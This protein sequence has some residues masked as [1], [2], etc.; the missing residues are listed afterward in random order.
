ML[1]SI[2]SKINGNNVSVDYSNNKTGLVQSKTVN[3]GTP[4]TYSYD[5][6][7]QVTS[8]T[9]P[10]ET[11]QYDNVGNLTCNQS[12]QNLTYNSTGELNYAYSTCG[13]TTTQQDTYTYDSYGDRVEEQFPFNGQNVPEYYAY[14]NSLGEMTPYTAFFT[15]TNYTYSGS[16]QLMYENQ[17]STFI[18]QMTYNEATTIPEIISNGTWDFIYGPNNLIFEAIYIGSSS[19]TPYYMIL[20]NVG[21]PLADLTQTA[22]IT[23]LSN[24][25]TWGY[26]VSNANSSSSPPIGFD[27]EYY[28]G[29]TS[30][31]YMSNRFYD[32]NTGQFLTQDPRIL[33]T[34]INYGYSGIA[35]PTTGGQLNLAPTQINQTQIYQF[36]N[37]DPVNL[38]DRS[39]LC[40]GCSTNGA[41]LALTMSALST[42][43]MIMSATML[44]SML[45]IGGL[46]G[47]AVIGVFAIANMRDLRENVG[48]LNDMSDS[49]AQCHN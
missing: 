5:S 42:E 37:D 11:F 39:G 49:T 4:T 29:P 25:N 12:G 7:G 27:N 28:D 10:N 26:S 38:V 8:A 43:S 47:I 24:D 41:A 48:F 31:Y 34:G 19:N 33:A 35:N 13:S 3:S 30:L 20:D 2:T 15:Q 32:P 46:A 44:P 40:G 23:N 9:N 16:G 17:G 18:A 1:T 21:T 6:L 36:A 45:M 14:I 22:Q